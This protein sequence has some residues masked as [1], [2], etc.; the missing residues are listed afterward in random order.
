[1]GT[2][3]S[4]S[5]GFNLNFGNNVHINLELDTRAETKKLF[6]ALSA[7]GKVSTD[8]QDTC[9]GSYFG[10]CTGKYGVQWMFTCA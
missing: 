2:D 5:T 1:M 7:K 10:T 3:A 8:L 9:W 6:T 4:E